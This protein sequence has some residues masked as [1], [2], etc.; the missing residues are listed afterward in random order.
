[1]RLDYTH[2]LKGDTYGSSCIGTPSIRG[3][4]R[5][6]NHNFGVDFVKHHVR[7]DDVGAIVGTGIDTSDIRDFCLCSGESERKER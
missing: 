4:Y 7:L 3:H 5:P 1:M 2:L 6:L